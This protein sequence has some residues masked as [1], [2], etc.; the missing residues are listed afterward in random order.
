MSWRAYIWW[1]V[2][3]AEGIQPH[4]VVVLQALPKKGLGHVMDRFISQTNLAVP[5]RIFDITS[6]CA[7]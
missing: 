6:I 1:R 2:K 4:F 7:H 5:L 3:F